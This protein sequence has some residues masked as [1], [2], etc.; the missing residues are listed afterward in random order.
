MH[1]FTTINNQC[2]PIHV[3]VVSQPSWDQV[4]IKNWT[5]IFQ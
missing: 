1:S 2:L 4:K 3:H 5:E